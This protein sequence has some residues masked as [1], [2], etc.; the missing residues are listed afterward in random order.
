L[1]G[2]YANKSWDI[3]L[4][5]ENMRERSGI[6]TLWAREKIRGLMDLLSAGADKEEVRKEVVK[7]A[8]DYNLVSRYTSM[9]A[10][11]TTPTRPMGKN[12][13]KTLT[14]ANL[15]EGW[16]YSKVFQL[17]QTATVA[18]LCFVLGL[19]SF[20]LAIIASLLVIDEW[21]ADK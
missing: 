9:L 3:E 19:L 11:D 16:I 10:V 4:T 14:T 18:H 6:A 13:Q 7:T 17:P 1:L 12:L 15:P 5:P 2:H 21:R 20:L 8:L